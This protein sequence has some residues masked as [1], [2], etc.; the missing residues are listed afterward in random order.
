MLMAVMQD[1]ADQHKKEW[2][3]DIRLKKLW[4]KH[5]GKYKLEYR[6]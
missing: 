5:Y 6:Q 4:A 1:F 3:E 2:E